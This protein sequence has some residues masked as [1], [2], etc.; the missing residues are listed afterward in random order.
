[1][2]AN[3]ETSYLLE[4]GGISRKLRFHC[5]CQFPGCAVT[6]RMTANGELEALHNEM[7][8]TSLQAQYLPGEG[9]LY[10]V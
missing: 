10:V 6:R 8:V 7:D 2:P 3:L 5:T 1:M 9:I 4:V